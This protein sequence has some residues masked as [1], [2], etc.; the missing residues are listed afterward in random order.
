MWGADSGRR[1]GLGTLAPPGPG[2]LGCRSVAAG[3]EV[4]P[5]LARGAL[6]R[7]AALGGLV[8]PRHRLRGD[9]GG[10]R[11]PLGSGG[12]CGLGSGGTAG[13]YPRLWEMTP[14]GSG[15]RGCAWGS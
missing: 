1:P 10:E 13:G 3:G 7:G 14:L 4:F 15:V 6:C 5:S 2:A 9:A 11:T 12:G 8:G